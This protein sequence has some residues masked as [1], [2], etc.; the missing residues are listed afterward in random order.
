M[1]DEPAKPGRLGRLRHPRETRLEL[2]ER[3]GEAYG[4]VLLLILITFA[5]MMTLPPEGWGGRVAPSRLP[6]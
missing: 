2:V 3:I 4:L 1:P 5:V 6:G